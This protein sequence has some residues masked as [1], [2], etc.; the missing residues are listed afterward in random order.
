M[1]IVGLQQSVV[2]IFFFPLKDSYN[3][4][5]MQYF[6]ANCILI[7]S[8][9]TKRF[10]MPYLYILILGLRFGNMFSI[11]LHRALAANTKHVVGH[12]SVIAIVRH[13][14]FLVLYEF[15]LA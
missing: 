9:L 7:C 13:V 1:L 11:G 4:F 5:E 10:F 15:V 12:K 6:I 3:L 14:T 8:F 2:S